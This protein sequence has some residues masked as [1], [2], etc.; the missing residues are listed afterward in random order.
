MIANKITTESKEQRVRGKGNTAALLIFSNSFTGGTKGDPDLV[1]K[2][3]MDG[4]C[5][6]KRKQYKLPL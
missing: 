2:T 4:N 6:I 5:R 3:C 1:Q